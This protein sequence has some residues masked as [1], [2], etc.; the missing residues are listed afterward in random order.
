MN[1]T[2]GCCEGVEP[3]TPLAT[4]NRPGLDALSYRAG[5]HATFLETMKAR[6]SAAEYQALA[7]LTTRAANDPSIA[8]L[9]AWATVADVLT[10]YQERIANEGYLR[11]ATERR[12]ILELARLVGYVPRPGVAASAYLAFTLEDGLRGRDTGRHPR[13]EPARSRRAAPVLRDL[14]RAGGPRRMEP[15]HAAAEPAPVSANIDPSRDGDTPPRRLYLKGVA[16]NLEPNDPLLIDFG[17][18]QGFFKAQTVEPDPE[19]GSYP[20][21]VRGCGRPHGLVREYGSRISARRVDGYLDLEAY[22]VSRESRTTGRVVG[23]LEE[24]REELTPRRRRRSWRFPCAKGSAEVRQDLDTARAR[25][26]R[27]SLPG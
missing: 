25:N 7:G 18:S 2:R 16:T 3:L 21:Y 10:F 17:A 4:A 14:R 20:G 23:L 27:N 8:L 1:E 22:E 5:T 13:P 24:L 11:T 15:P 9:D 19:S 6:L 12:S 26:Y